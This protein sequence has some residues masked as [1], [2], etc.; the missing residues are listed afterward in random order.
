MKEKKFNEI[1]R[2]DHLVDSCLILRAHP[3]VT[4]ERSY[5][6]KA[7]TEKERKWRRRRRAA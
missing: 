1:W 5:W 6:S 4:T 2:I 3:R 7:L